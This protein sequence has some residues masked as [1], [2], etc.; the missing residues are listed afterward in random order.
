MRNSKITL[1]LIRKKKPDAGKDW[2]QEEKGETADKMV[3]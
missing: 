2:G 3:G 1:N